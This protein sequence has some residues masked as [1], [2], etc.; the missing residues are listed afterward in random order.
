MKAASGV[1]P[2]LDVATVMDYRSKTEKVFKQG[3]PA[4]RKRLLRNWIQEVKLK[5]ETLARGEHQLPP[6]GI[7]YEW[8]GCGGLQC[9]ERA[10]H[11]LQVRIA[12]G[13]MNSDSVC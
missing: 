6:P 13:G 3:D 9:S 5:P 2:Q 12:A 4:D 11:C 7:R 10:F 8:F 1:P